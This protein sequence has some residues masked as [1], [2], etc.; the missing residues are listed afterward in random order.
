MAPS[1]SRIL[2]RSS[3]SSVIGFRK[4]KSPLQLAQKRALMRVSLAV[5]VTR[6]QAEQS[7]RREGGILP[8]NACS[9]NGL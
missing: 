3:A 9:V 2:S 7:N 6:P 5:F 8:I 1:S 4:S